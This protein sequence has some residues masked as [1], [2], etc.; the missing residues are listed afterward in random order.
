MSEVFYINRQYIRNEDKISDKD[1][2]VR[3]D[4][5]DDVLANI[6]KNY[7]WNKARDKVY[8]LQCI[9]SVASYHRNMEEIRRVQNK[10][11]NS[12]E[13]KMLSV[14]KV[15]EELKSV[16]G[17]D[18]VR[19]RTNSDKIRAAMSLTAKDYKAKPFK[20]FCFQDKKRLKER[21]VGIPCLYDRAMHV[22]YSYALEP[23]AEAW[24][25]RNSFGFRKGRSAIHAHAQLFNVLTDF[26]T[27]DW[28]LVA[29]IK[30]YYSSISHKWLLDNI[31]MDTRVLKEF[32]KVGMCFEN[33]EIFPTEE[34]INLGCTI[35]P[36]LR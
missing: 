1:I 6:W 32:L 12:S 5:P 33:G 20:H 24:A 8:K 29:D 9:L 15:T 23:V 13:A 10:I 11:V 35:S 2:Y 26:E 14:K 21:H 18:G 25:D 3:I 17:I 30:S 16:A 22:L 27:G 7:D 36:I 34:G 4:F 19:W 31:P 28:I